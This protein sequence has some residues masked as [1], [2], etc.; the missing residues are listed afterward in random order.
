MPPSPRI[1]IV[2]NDPIITHLV[3]TMLQKKGYTIAGIV[4]TGGEALLKS[5]FIL[6]VIV[7]FLEIVCVLV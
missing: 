4:N 7:L 2:D 3:S 6:I 5:A 1:L